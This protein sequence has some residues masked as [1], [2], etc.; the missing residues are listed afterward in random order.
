MVL[1]YIY[2]YTFAQTKTAGRL[3][4][5]K[6]SNETVD[7]FIDSGSMASVS[8][9]GSKFGQLQFH[10]VLG[11]APYRVSIAAWVFIVRV[12]PDW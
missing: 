7:P 12:L 9:L 10:N 6:L 2:L 8:F 3:R 11:Y 4:S 1:Q 5:F